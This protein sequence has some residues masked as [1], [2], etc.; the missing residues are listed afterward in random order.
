[1]VGWIGRSISR[2][3]HGVGRVVGGSAEQAGIAQTMGEDGPGQHPGGAMMVGAARR[4]GKA[5]NE[6]PNDADP[7][8]AWRDR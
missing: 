7:E 5:T 8:R 3:V 6:M 2:M 1:M 4:I